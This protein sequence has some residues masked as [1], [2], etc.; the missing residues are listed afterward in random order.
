[1]FVFF[2]CFRRLGRL[3]I[4]RVRP[5]IAAQQ[6]YGS[7]DLRLAEILFHLQGHA[8]PFGIVEVHAGE[9]PV[10]M[11]HLAERSDVV[12]HLLENGW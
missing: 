3:F 9:V 1:M 5:A 4:L 2:L 11:S 10:A 6:A 7:I 8:G 12:A